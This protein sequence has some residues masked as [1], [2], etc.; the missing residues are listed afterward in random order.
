MEQQS[1]HIYYT[2]QVH[3]FDDQPQQIEQQMQEP[4][5]FPELNRHILTF[6]HLILTCMVTY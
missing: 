5:H 2:L 4:N 3:S 6:L 1:E